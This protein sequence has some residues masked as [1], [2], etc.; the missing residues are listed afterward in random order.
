[1]MRRKQRDRTR[2]VSFRLR[3]A[4]ISLLKD[5][6][7]SYGGV[8]RAIQVATELLW[9][10]RWARIKP[11]V[12]QEGNDDK[13]QELFAF[14]ALPRTVEI[15]DQLAKAYYEGHR[16]KVIRACVQLLFEMRLEHH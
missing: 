10:R 5:L 9:A 13:P 15:I 12:P 8:G 14:A 6:A 1:M 2:V 4:T 16:N 7:G 3:P 11:V